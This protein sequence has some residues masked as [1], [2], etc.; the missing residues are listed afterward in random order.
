MGY[1]AHW[2]VHWEVHW[3]AHWEAHWEVEVQ[4]HAVRE[5]AEAEEKLGE[6]PSEGLLLWAGF[7]RASLEWLR[8]EAIAWVGA[9]ACAVQEAD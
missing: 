8:V 2:E 5:A 1:E 9:E 3:E 6:F 7:G 4:Q